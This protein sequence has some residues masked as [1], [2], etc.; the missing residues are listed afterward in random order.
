MFNIDRLSEL[1]EFT[2]T[3][4]TIN[5]SPPEEDKLSQDAV[6]YFCESHTENPQV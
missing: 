1:N 4:A 6:I 2:T 3:V 5:N